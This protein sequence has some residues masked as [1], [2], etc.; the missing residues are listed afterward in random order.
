VHPDMAD[1]RAIDDPKHCY[2][3]QRQQC[4]GECQATHLLCVQAWTGGKHAH[5]RCAARRA[6]SGSPGWGG[7]ATL[8][9]RPSARSR[10]WE[11]ILLSAFTRLPC[12]L[13]LSSSS[14]YTASK[15]CSMA[16]T[17]HRGR[18]I[19]VLSSRRPPAASH[20][21]LTQQIYCICMILCDFG[22]TCLTSVYKG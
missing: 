16:A 21:F 13:L 10:S 15:R 11:P 6:Q 22:S 2:A 12:L 17:S 19:H 1:D 14:S 20:A 5:L 4:A 7:A 8:R 9:A 18:H 3:G